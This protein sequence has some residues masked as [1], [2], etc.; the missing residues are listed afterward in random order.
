[1][2]YEQM[3]RQELLTEIKL[4]VTENKE[5]GNELGQALSDLEDIVDKCERQSTYYCCFC[6]EH[7]NTC[8]YEGCDFEWRGYKEGI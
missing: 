5:L 4:L 6:C 3:S 8:K 1:M 2:N 7:Y